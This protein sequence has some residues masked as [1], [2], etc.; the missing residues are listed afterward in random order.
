MAHVEGSGTAL[1]TSVTVPAKDK[2][3][4][5]FPHSPSLAVQSEPLYPLLIPLNVLFTISSSVFVPASNPP[6]T[7]GVAE[8]MSPLA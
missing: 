8:V 2:L 5:L 4:G 3:D 1:A 7:T 6:T